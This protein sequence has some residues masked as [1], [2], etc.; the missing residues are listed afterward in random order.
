MRR[1]CALQATTVDGGALWQVLSWGT[2]S[3]GQLGWGST[4]IAHEAGQAEVP[5]LCTQ[6]AAG[7]EHSLALDIDGSVWAWGDNAHGQLGSEGGLRG[8]PIRVPLGGGQALSIAA[9]SRSRSSNPGEPPCPEV[10]VQRVRARE[11]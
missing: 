6:I 5:N 10:C 8:K 2:N 3:R 11:R 1:T 7:S 4:D 9:V